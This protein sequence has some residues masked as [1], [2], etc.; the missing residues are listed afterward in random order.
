MQNLSKIIELI[1]TYNYDAIYYS[2][3]S[4]NKL[5]TGL[6][7]VDQNVINYIDQKI[8]LLSTKETIYL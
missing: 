2:V 3:G 8:Q 1:K 6:F 4:N 7:K 5:G